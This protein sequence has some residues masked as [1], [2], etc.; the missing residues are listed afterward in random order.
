MNNRKII[1]RV[2]AMLLIF[3]VVIGGIACG[4]TSD[5]TTTTTQGPNN[6]NQNQNTKQYSQLLQNVLND[7]YYDS[8]LNQVISGNTEI[9]KTG[10]FAPHPYAFLEDEGYDVDAIRQAPNELSRTI[11]YVLEDEPNNLYMFTRVLIDNSYYAVYHLRYTL[12]DKE[13]ED[14]NFLFD[15]NHQFAETNLNF[16]RESAFINDKI[17]EMKTPT[18]LGESKIHIN[19][20]E[21]LDEGW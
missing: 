4:N 7:E 5:T 3:V 21:K 14:Y 15:G 11:T 9:L 10:A 16:L 6:N 18:V 12:T 13:M 2:T 1:N 17:S 20:I 19:G 8:L